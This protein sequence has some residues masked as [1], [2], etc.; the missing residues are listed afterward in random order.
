MPGFRRTVM[1]HKLTALH[2]LAIGACLAALAASPERLPTNEQALEQCLRHHP[3][4]FC[5]ITYAGEQ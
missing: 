1:S 2:L 5:R 4:R 3:Q